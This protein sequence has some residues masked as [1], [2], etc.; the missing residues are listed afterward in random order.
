MDTRDTLGQ[1]QRAMALDVLCSLGS[2]KWRHGH[3][4][5]NSPNVIQRIARGNG[6]LVCGGDNTTKGY[7]GRFIMSSGGRTPP[8]VNDLNEPMAWAA[9]DT[10]SRA[11]KTDSSTRD[12][13]NVLGA[14]LGHAE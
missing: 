2:P 3:C 7:R 1:A 14:T 13:Y 11:I 6:L 12:K 8:L 5:A 10:G 4:P 9:E